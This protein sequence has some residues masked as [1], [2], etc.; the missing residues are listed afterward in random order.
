MLRAYVAEFIG[1]FALLFVV[2]GGIASK[3]DTLGV[4]LA[5]GIVIAAMIAALG[6]A[7]GA[8]FNPSV[9]LGLLLTKRISL[10]DALA[11]WAA[12]LLGA[13]LAVGLLDL[14]LG[15]EKLSAVG[16]GV[17][18]LASGVS[19]G[20]GLVIEIVLTFFL[21]LVIVTTAVHLKNPAAATYIGLAVALGILAGAN[22]TGAAM[23]PA[24]AFGSAVW[25][26]GFEHHWI[27]WLGPL[28]G[29]VL[30]TWVADWMYKK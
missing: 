29:G 5:N 22:L 6:P 7:S 20:T 4:V 21:V 18:R 13:S 23:N 19:P 10:N 16:Y 24:R 11:Y 17:P 8:H 12:Q 26:G 25:G 27:Y 15:S 9:T 14:L 1:T 30:A 28:T 2:V 3:I